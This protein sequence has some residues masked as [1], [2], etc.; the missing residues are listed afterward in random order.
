MANI[1][2]TEV[3]FEV[4]L[5]L[6]SLQR[7]LT[8]LG[9]IVIVSSHN[10]EFHLWC[11]PQKQLKHNFI[12]TKLNKKLNQAQS[13]I[14]K[15]LKNNKLL[16]K[17][18]NCILRNELVHFIANAN[19]LFSVVKGKSK[20]QRRIPF[21]SGMYIIYSRR[22]APNTTDFV[23]MTAHFIDLKLKMIDVTISIPHVQGQHSG[24]NYVNLFYDVMRN[25][26]LE[27]LQTITANNASTNGNIAPELFLIIH[28]HMKTHLLGCIAHVI[29]L[30]KKCRPAVL[31]TINHNDGEEIS[32]ADIEPDSEATN[33][34]ATSLISISQIPSKPNEIGIDMKTILKQVHGLSTYIQF[35]PQHRKCFLKLPRHSCF[36]PME[37]HLSYVP[38]RLQSFLISTVGSQIDSSYT[39]YEATRNAL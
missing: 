23:G 38:A 33:H 29:N 7:M 10:Q 6:G 26:C 1:S 4:K 39:P 35:S 32:M 12:D 24:K 30:G 13:D 17:A 18:F 31:G 15:F 8:F 36:H 22:S 14:T 21:E 5:G 27:K 16:P 2:A 9:G 19:L 34:T 37:L 28:F 20:V 11:F 25:G 3:F